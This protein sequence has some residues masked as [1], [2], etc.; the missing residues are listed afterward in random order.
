[1]VI[2]ATTVEADEYIK[3]SVDELPGDTQNSNQIED[4]LSF[5]I[6]KEDSLF[7]SDRDVED[8]PF[9]RETNMGVMK[10]SRPKIT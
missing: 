6:E 3:H 4:D 8:S 5:A 10:H 7:E 2:G 9:Q 1:M